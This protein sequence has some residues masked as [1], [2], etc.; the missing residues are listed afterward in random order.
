MSDGQER[1]KIDIVHENLS[2]IRALEN[3][4]IRKHNEH[5]SHDSQLTGITANC[6]LFVISLLGVMT[7][8]RSR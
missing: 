3:V 5:L 6:H 1:I 7:Y 8:A 2:I 4:A